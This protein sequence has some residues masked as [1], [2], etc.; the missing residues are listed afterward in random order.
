MNIKGVLAIV[1]GALNQHTELDVSVF[2]LPNVN[3]KGYVVTLSNI[4]TETN[5]SKNCVAYN[6]DGAIFKTV[7]LAE[8]KDVGLFEF[9]GET[10]I[11]DKCNITFEREVKFLERMDSQADIGFAIKCKFK[12]IVYVLDN[13]YIPPIKSIGI[14]INNSTLIIEK[15]E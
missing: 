5:K 13:T 1:H 3:Y 10:I 9:S 11:N 6:V 15:G 12:A 8:A 4:S 14:D 2:Y 7:E